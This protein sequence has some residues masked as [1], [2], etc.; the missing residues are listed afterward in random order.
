MTAMTGNADFDRY[1]LPSWG[2]KVCLKVEQ[3]GGQPGLL[4]PAIGGSIGLGH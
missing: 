1:T 4:K 3:N 2:G